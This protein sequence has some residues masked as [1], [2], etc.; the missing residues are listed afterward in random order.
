M[1]RRDQ[2]VDFDTTQENVDKKQ[3]EKIKKK[4]ELRLY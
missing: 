2:S 3:L 1:E 4:K